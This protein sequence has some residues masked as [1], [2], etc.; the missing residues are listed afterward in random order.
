[1]CDRPGDDSTFSNKWKMI[2]GSSV[3]LRREDIF[4]TCTLRSL[5]G[6]YP[7]DSSVLKTCVAEDG[8]KSLPTLTKPRKYGRCASRR[9]YKICIK[10]LTQNKHAVN[11]ARI[12][13]DQVAARYRRPGI[14]NKAMRHYKYSIAIT[15]FDYQVANYQRS[16]SQFFHPLDQNLRKISIKEVE[17]SDGSVSTNPQERSLRFLEHWESIWVTLT[18]RLDVNLHQT[19]ERRASSSTRSRASSMKQIGCSSTQP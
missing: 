19:K 15:A 9:S 7:E 10:L 1:M 14:F 13:L 2:M 4:K 11:D 5:D 3:P 6:Y 17:A 8:F 12:E 18:L 16:I